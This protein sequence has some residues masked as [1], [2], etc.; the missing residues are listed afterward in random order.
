MTVPKPSDRIIK[1]QELIEATFCI[2]SFN[3]TS[4]PG[5]PISPIEI[6]LT[7]DRLSLI[8]RVLSSNSEAYKHPKV[9]LDIL[10]KLGFK[11]NPTAEIKALGMISDVALRDENF[12]RALNINKRIIDSITGLKDDGA[13]VGEEVGEVC[14]A[15]NNTANNFAASPTNGTSNEPNES[16]GTGGLWHR[17]RMAG[18]FPS[19]HWIPT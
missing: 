2:Y 18:V 3:V 13:D 9:I 15:T 14:L 19:E 6:R 17:Y 1:E 7:K 12:D 5:T 16:A 8:S 10:R 11:G 4:R